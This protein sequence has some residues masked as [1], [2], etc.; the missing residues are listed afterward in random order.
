MLG[1]FHLGV[2]GALNTYTCT[3][4]H[5]YEVEMLCVLNISCARETKFCR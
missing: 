4:S 1:V 3:S 2:C 5:V